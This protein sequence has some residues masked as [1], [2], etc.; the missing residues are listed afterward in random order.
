MFWKNTSFILVAC[1]LIA[2]LQA[3]TLDDKC[4]PRFFA[5][6]IKYEE[7]VEIDF[8]YT[9]INLGSTRD[10]ARFCAQR[11]FCRSAVYN[12]RTRTCGISYE[13]TVPCASNPQRYDDFELKGRNQGDLIHIACV[14]SCKSSSADKNDGERV[15]VG[16]I[17]GEPNDGKIAVKI[18]DSV[19]NNVITDPLTTEK[20]RAEGYVT[21]LILANISGLQEGGVGSIEPLTLQQND[22]NKTSTK[23]NASGK[24]QVC[25]RTIRHRYLLG[26]T[27]EEHD[28]N[29]I[30]E[31]RCLCAA[32]YKSNSTQKCQSFQ[33][34]AGKCS[35]N[36]GNHLGQ[37]DLIEKRR[38]VYQYVDCDIDVLL[39]VASNFCANFKED[40]STPAPTTTLAPKSTTKKPAPTTTTKKPAAKPTTTQKTTTTTKKPAPKATTQKPKPTPKGKPTKP[41]TTTTTTVT[42]KTTTVRETGDDDVVASD[43]NIVKSGCFE[44]INDH[45]MVSVA[46]GL[47]HDVTIEECQCICANSKKSGKYEFQCASATYYHIE[48][49]C[50]LNLED[51]HMKPKLFEKQFVNFNVSYIGTTCSTEKTLESTKDLASKNCRKESPTTT[52]PVNKKSEKKNGKNSDSCFIELNDFVLEGTA[53]AVEVTDSPQDCKCKCAQGEKLYGEECASFLYY[54]D[55]KT[56]LINKQNRFSNPEKFN[57]VP[58]INQTRSYFEWTCANKD[59]ARIKYLGDVCQVQSDPVEGN[60]LNNDAEKIETD[61]GRVLRLDEKDFLKRIDEVV[62]RNEVKVVEKKSDIKPKKN[63][64]DDILKRIQDAEKTLSTMVS[65]TPSTTT[66][67]K[68][69][70]PTTTK[71]PTT[72]TEKPTEK[73]KITTKKPRSVPVTST[74]TQKPK[75]E[76]STIVKTKKVD[77]K[78]LLEKLSQVVADEKEKVASAS[79]STKSDAATVEMKKVNE[80][81]IIQKINEANRLLEAS[82]TEQ[83]KTTTTAE[84]I[85]NKKKTTKKPPVVSSPADD[86][87]KNGT[88]SMKTVTAEELEQLSNAKIDETPSEPKIVVEEGN[89]GMKRVSS[90]Q[91][92]AFEKAEIKSSEKKE[93]KEKV[94]EKKT[95]GKYTIPEAEGMEDS[96]DEETVEEQITESLNSELSD[97]TTPA[98]SVE[99]TVTTTAAPITTST[100]QSKP[101]KFDKKVDKE[102][103][104]LPR[105]T[106]TPATT[107]TTLGYP[108]AGRCSYSA[109]YQTSFLGRR[110]LK[111]VHVKTPADCFAAC[112]ALR[113]RSANLIAQ[114]GLNSCELYKDSLIDYRRPDMIGYDASTVY[115]DGINCDGSQ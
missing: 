109:L 6:G 4:S 112:Y 62:D 12:S 42:P 91:I 66:T 15:P 36:K 74:T 111:T 53:I 34:K 8:Y 45:L 96:N 88:V 46:G 81:E 99:T 38:T 65:T 113:C 83:P 106:T 103:M 101:Q 3:A 11:E 14:D 33:Y 84:L 7:A 114:G 50:I 104:P 1:C 93:E 102:G 55:S 87:G 76:D 52:T 5:K 56:C 59:E 9:G 61:S 63:I 16:I 28:V 24:S 60:L 20:P 37:Y 13:F 57:F 58:S 54:Y 10:C 21:R 79:K 107:T 72:T 30:N 48:R 35:I 97:E 78:T 71:K 115:F 70:T 86:N 44:I 27:F 43:L 64:K 23:G 98:S 85:I 89:V 69:I 18:T 31:C 22:E 75:T 51:R 39:D 105:I 68:K 67:T 92:K 110:L 100:I 95:T 49:D 32:T 29:S 47:E 2:S 26:A 73:P 25:Y 17:T 82:S 41:A 19:K 77:E 80:K 40:A 90:E 94:T 108:P